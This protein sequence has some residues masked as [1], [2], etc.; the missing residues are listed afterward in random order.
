ASNAT[1]ATA[2]FNRDCM[3][4]PPLSGTPRRFALTLYLPPAVFRRSSKRFTREYMQIVDLFNRM[5]HS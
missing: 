4:T 5:K 1:P 2:D 3:F